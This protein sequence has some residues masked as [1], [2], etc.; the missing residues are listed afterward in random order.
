MSDHDDERGCRVKGCPWTG[1]PD[2]CP[3]THYDREMGDTRI[4]RLMQQ[5]PDA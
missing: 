4:D 2:E 1:P 5:R 3:F